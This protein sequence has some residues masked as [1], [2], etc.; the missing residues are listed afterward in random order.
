[1]QMQS[2][3]KENITNALR[4]SFG[5]GRVL[6]IGDIMLEARASKTDSPPVNCQNDRAAV[7][8]SLTPA[9]AVVLCDEK[10]RL[11]QI[12]L[13]RPDVL[14]MDASDGRDLASNFFEVESCV[15]RVEVFPYLQK[16]KRA[17]LYAIGNRPMY[18]IS[19]R[20]FKW[21]SKQLRGK[22]GI[23]P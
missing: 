10:T 5:R 4:N 8:A 14:V 16:R 15:G 19:S 22:K 2:P 9:D 7:I 21:Q 13:L 20:K 6:V 17:R 18:E 11:E 12:R 1:V 23:R 3:D